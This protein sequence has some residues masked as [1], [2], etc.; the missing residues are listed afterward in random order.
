MSDTDY[1]EDG[2]LDLDLDT[3]INSIL[4]QPQKIEITKK[5]KT[6]DKQRKALA[7]ARKQKALKKE[8]GKLWK[9]QGKEL[10]EK[11]TMYSIYAGTGL[12]ILGAGYYTIQ[13]NE[14][15]RNYV[16]S[17]GLKQSYQNQHPNYRPMARKP[18]IKPTPKTPK[19]ETPPPPPKKDLIILDTPPTPPPIIVP[20]P[21]Q[22][23]EIKEI[24]LEIIGDEMKE[25]QEKKKPE[26]VKEPIKIE[27]KGYVAKPLD[28]F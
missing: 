24:L 28:F 19:I 22:K 12:L 26:I 13:Q 23:E 14:L 1:S 11:Y 2:S 5:K 20:P 25:S 7:N 17:W 27:K 6:S 18:I 16:K 10:W 4:D 3:Y 15:L 9:E 8:A 21:K